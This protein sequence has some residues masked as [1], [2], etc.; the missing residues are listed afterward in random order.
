MAPCFVSSTLSMQPLRM[1][2]SG[3]RQTVALTFLTNELL[4]S[5]DPFSIKNKKVAEMIAKVEM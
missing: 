1:L 2:I 4:S 3:C 5:N